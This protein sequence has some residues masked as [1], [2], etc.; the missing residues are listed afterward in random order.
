MTQDIDERLGKLLR[1]DAPPERDA[2]FRIALLERRERKRFRH[3]SLTLLA[4]AAVLG[5]VPAVALTLVDNPLAA[6]V[7][8]IF[9]M[10]LIGASLSSFRGVLQVMRWLRG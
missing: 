4:A 3:R 7:I 9:G 6:G 10:A 1:A 5:V 2:L 8:A